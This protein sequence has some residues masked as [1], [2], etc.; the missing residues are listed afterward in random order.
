MPSGLMAW[1]PAWQVSQQCGWLSV[2]VSQTVYGVEHARVPILPPISFKLLSKSMIQSVG[3][4][5]TSKFLP[6]LTTSQLLQRGR[7]PDTPLATQLPCCGLHPIRLPRRLSW[8]MPLSFQSTSTLQVYS[9]CA[10]LAP[11]CRLK[12]KDNDRW[13]EGTYPFHPTSLPIKQTCTRVDSLLAEDYKHHAW[14]A[15]EMKHM[16]C[17]H[18]IC[19]SVCKGK[20]SFPTNH[21]M[22]LVSSLDG[23][24]F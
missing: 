19:K 24:G 18:S 15:G 9:A 7:K 4:L 6:H 17:P 12:Q 21:S 5:S 2:V 10:A 11:R 22:P 14:A 16:T 13:K 20:C 3:F 23:C 8:R 1:P